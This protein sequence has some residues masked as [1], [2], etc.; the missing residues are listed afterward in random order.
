MTGDSERLR[1]LNSLDG[2]E[3]SEH[4]TKCCGSSRW[5]AAMAQRRPFADA[6]QLFAVAEEVWNGLT[7]E[8]WKEAFSHHPKIGDISSLREKFASTKTWA[9]GEQ[10]GVNNTTENTLKA[11]AEGNA[12][13]EKKFG[14]IFIVCAT[15]K[16]AEEM[17]SL[18]KA[19]RVNTPDMEI[20]IAAAEQNKITRI[21]LEKLLL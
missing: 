3:A 6:R 7:P 11:L 9:A 18:L 14:F 20:A 12:E 8:D 16:S 10:S 13:Y 2:Q 19:R 4:F 5:V 15:G 1:W 17:L 21:R